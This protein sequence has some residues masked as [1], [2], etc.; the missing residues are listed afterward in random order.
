MI[1]ILKIIIL[2]YTIS[3]SYADDLYPFINNKQTTQ[4]NFLLRELRC[5]V[6]K[7]QDLADSNSGFAQDLRL[8]VYKLVQKGWSDDE[9][10]KYL[11]QR[12]GDFILFKPRVYNLTLLLWLSP[13]IFV[14]I[15]LIIFLKQFKTK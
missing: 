8:Q 9:I 2:L 12:Y 1:K 4:F 13:I 15:G 3:F 14:I 5:L 10:L 11:Q 7:N 6:C